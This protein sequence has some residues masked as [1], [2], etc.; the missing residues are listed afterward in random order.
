MLFHH[1]FPR[2]LVVLA[3][4]SRM[5]SVI[6]F[7]A[8]ALRNVGFNSSTMHWMALCFETAARR[9][10]FLPAWAFHEVRY[11]LRRQEVVQNLLP[12]IVLDS[13]ELIFERPTR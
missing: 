3:K 1:R 13:Y 2:V 6:R 5:L 9:L 12:D 7:T 10:V 4:A 8:G 11:V